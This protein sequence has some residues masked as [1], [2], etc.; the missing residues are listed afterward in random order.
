[1]AQTGNRDLLVG[2]FAIQLGFIDATGFVAAA[3]AWIHERGKPLVDVL[4]EKG[5][6]TEDDRNLLDRLVDRHI[7]QFGSVDQSLDEMT[8][9][10]PP[11]SFLTEISLEEL[12]H[13]LP[14]S[15]LDTIHRLETP[16]MDVPQ[17]EPL[18]PTT[19]RYRIVRDL[20][21][22]GLGKVSVAHDDELD[23]EVALKE[24]QRRHSGRR[25]SQLRFLTEARITG[26]LEHPGVVPIYSL[27]NFSDGRP[28]YTM[29][30]IKGKTL[31]ARIKEERIA[32][33]K[34]RAYEHAIRPLVNHL[35]DVC[36]TI[37]YAHSRAVLHR[38]IKPTNIMLGK[39]GETLVVDWGLAKAN[40]SAGSD[41]MQSE[42]PLAELMESGSQATEFGSVIGTPSYMSPEQA[43]GWVDQIDTRSDIFSLG[44]TLYHILTGSAPYEGFSRD[45]IVDRARKW[46]LQPLRSLQP[47]VP[48]E[49]NAICLKA[50][51]KNRDDRYASAK[52]LAE[53]L[54]RWSAGEP[55]AALP[56]GPIR[57]TLRWTRRHQ[58]ALLSG[59]AMS[60]L[61]LVGMTFLYGKAER[62]R[63]DE[64]KA[65]QARYASRE[66]ASRVIELFI[67]QLADD[68]L[69]QD[70]AM[71]S[72]R[73]EMLR[74]AH[75]AL[76]Q[77]VHGNPDDLF[78]NFEKANLAMRL[79]NILRN[80]AASSGNPQLLH[81][82]KDILDTFKQVQR[83]IDP[84]L[85]TAKPEEIREWHALQ[86][87]GDYYSALVEIEVLEDRLGP[88]AKIPDAAM[89]SIAKITVH[90]RELCR[91]YLV[92]TAEAFSGKIAY[93]RSLNLE[94]KWQAR[95]GNLASA[96]M[97]LQ[98]SIETLESL[99]KDEWLQQ[100]AEWRDVLLIR[101]EA[102][103]LLA[104]CLQKASKP[105]EALAQYKRCRA[106]VAELTKI[107]TAVRDASEFDK[108]I[109][110]GIDESDQKP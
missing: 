60:L 84:L 54:E 57:S 71:D 108:R 87:G 82:A 72:K 21:R 106:F 80:R 93:A 30:L 33:L 44:A 95:L 74:T 3:R 11:S 20:A 61:G 78:L 59:L 53:D 92:E 41:P 37:A 89:E 98:Q 8:K 40:E 64:E 91:R 107:P 86:I 16:P 14:E 73:T 42:T 19:E 99:W 90:H 7:E 34:G 68:A 81:E 100:Q 83:N 25:E 35:I 26:S 17:P 23:R 110:D 28:Y 77:L 62:A 66:V 52:D 79:G 103:M 39:Y 15:W 97:W 51:A 50:M 101:I 29:R 58:P 36:N 88:D 69:A 22:G 63:L 75:A 1:M 70:V 10:H 46:E 76:G 56:E 94:A 43:N 13:V 104:E 2:I 47:A 31:A 102:E 24:I 96:Q 55:V 48:R 5:W 32:Q 109:S 65:T 9:H 12:K 67:N 38:D 27:G 49:L 6:I 45:D 85:L 18:D 4:V 105:K